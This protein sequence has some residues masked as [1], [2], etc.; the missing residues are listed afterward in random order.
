M[1]DKQIERC[2]ASLDIRDMYTKTTMRYH[3]KLTRMAT[4]F[5]FLNSD[6]SNVE[7]M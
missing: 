4:F 5:F 7:C 2:T 6:N 3:D 1:V